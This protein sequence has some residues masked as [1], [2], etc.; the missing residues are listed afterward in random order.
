MFVDLLGFI[1]VKLNK[2]KTLKKKT[3]IKF[4]ESTKLNIIMNAN[5]YNGKDDLVC[6]SHS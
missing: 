3:I 6:K 5:L 2:N 1:V 4:L